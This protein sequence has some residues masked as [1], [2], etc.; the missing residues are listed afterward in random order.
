M[1]ENKGWAVIL[2]IFL[3]ITLFI[4]SITCATMQDEVTSINVYTKGKKTAISLDKPETQ[5]IIEICEEQLKQADGILRLAVAS[6][7]IESIKNNDAAL[8]IIYRNPKT[9]FITFNKN[10]VE[11]DRLFIPLTGDFAGG[12]TTIFHGRGSYAAGPY[13][14]KDGTAAIS[15]IL[16]KMGFSFK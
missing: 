6:T 7:L 5:K 9:F 11:A 15:S 12:L 16:E 2:P 4:V 13:R 8:E 10:N 1:V 3:S 14:N